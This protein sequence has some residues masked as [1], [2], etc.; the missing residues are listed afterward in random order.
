MNRYLSA[1]LILSAPI[2]QLSAQ[3][4][5]KPALHG[6]NWMAITGKPLAATAG[7][8]IFQ[9]GGNAIDASCN[10]CSNLHYVGYP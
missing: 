1:L 7:A 2:L 6:H 5:Q 3:Q 10:A 8:M 4:T 9:K